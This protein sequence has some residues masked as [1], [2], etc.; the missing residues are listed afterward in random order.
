MK[1]PVSQK[2]TYK[3]PFRRRR[4]GL[5]DYRYRDKLLRSGLPRAVVRK[6]LKN[7]T[8]QFIEYDPKGDRIVAHAN[9]M[10]LK[11]LGWTGS[12]SN[13][14]AA[15]FTG[16]LAGKRAKNASITNA[17]LDIGLQTP[18]KGSKVFSALKGILDAGI[19]IPHNPE[20]LPKDDRLKGK[21]TDFESIRKKVQE[22]SPK[23]KGGD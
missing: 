8:V 7:T 9:S 19:H 14:T 23:K 20:V 5:T 1:R 15:Y 16:L 6:S 17:V 2:P 4:D 10:E 12:L 3:V 11:E 21:I 22:H 18:T 13:T